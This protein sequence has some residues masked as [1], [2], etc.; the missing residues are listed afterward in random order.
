MKGTV[1][2]P[3]PIRKNMS[4]KE[5]LRAEYEISRALARYLNRDPYSVQVVLEFKGDKACYGVLVN[6]KTPTGIELECVNDFF[7]QLVLVP[8]ES[9]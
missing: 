8:D 4:E 9:N 7:R 6:H 3:T 5:I 1:A 2:L